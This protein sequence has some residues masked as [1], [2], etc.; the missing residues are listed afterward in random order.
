MLRTDIANVRNLRTW[1]GS[2]EV[3]FNL[4][5]PT[6]LDAGE[7]QQAMAEF[8]EL[9]ASGKIDLKDLDGNQMKVP[10]QCVQNCPVEA[11][12]NQK[13]TLTWLNNNCLGEDI[14]PIVIAA[15]AMAIVLFILIF[16]ICAVCMKKKKTEEKMKPFTVNNII[17]H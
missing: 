8:S 2:V 9:I 1:P 17:S 13:H 4:V 7:Q 12:G 15:I 10:M 6:E 3:S 5:A 11:I 16:I 14:I